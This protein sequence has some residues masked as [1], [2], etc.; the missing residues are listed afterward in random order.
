[1]HIK[2]LFVI[3]IIS[4]IL[5]ASTLTRGHQWGDDFAWYILQAKSIWNGTTDEF[6]QQS[7][8]TN[9]QSTTYVGPLAY[10]WGY[11]LILIPSYAIKGIHPLALKLPALLFYAGFLVCLYLLMKARL[12]HTE[13]L[14][15]VSLFA[16]NPVLIQFLDQI[17]SDIPYLFFSTLSLWLITKEDKR[18]VQQNILIGVSIFLVTFLR[19][20]GILLLGCFLIVEFFKL[21]NHRRDWGAVR[22]IILD[23]SVVCVSFILLW[24]ANSILFPA[25]GDS[26]LSQYAGLSVDKVRNSI[27]AYFNVYSLFFGE[28]TGWRYLYYVLV[29]FFLI[30]TWTRWKEELYFLLFFVLWMIVHIA[31]PYWQGPRYIFPLLPIFIYFTFQGM[32][33]VIQKLPEK[34]PQIGYRILYGFWSL[35]TIIFL[36]NSSLNAYINLQHDRAINGPFDQY[37]NEVYKYIREDTPANSVIIFFKPRVM[38]LMTD[39]P[40]IMSTE[41]DRMLKGNVLVLNRKVGRNQQIPPEEIE[42]CHLPLNEVLKNSR[43]IV[44]EIQK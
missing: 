16:F 34:Y 41:C 17:L 39:H 7:A 9:A 43:F 21:I 1:M 8:F 40:T 26:Y 42:A 5:G 14:L 3:I 20:T 30:G 28:A 6:I 37:S 4:L 32:K 36:F 13:S 31:Y 12:S 18:S 19:A 29:V 15:L 27:A 23:S 38:V 33:F 2:F 35:I 11:P 10:P 24:I 22:Q 44:Y 25:G